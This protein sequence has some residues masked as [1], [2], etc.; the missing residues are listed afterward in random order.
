MGMPYLNSLVVNKRINCHSR[1][2]IISGICLL[3]KL[4]PP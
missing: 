1:G 3:P 4:C 2:F